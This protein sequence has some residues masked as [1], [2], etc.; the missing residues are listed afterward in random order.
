MER[1]ERIRMVEW[2]NGVC[3]TYDHGSEARQ[4]VTVA[5]HECWE[6]LE[7]ASESMREGNVPWGK[8]E[9]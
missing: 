8:D 4:H 2:W 6:C 5:R 1:N 7:L 9:D 3:I